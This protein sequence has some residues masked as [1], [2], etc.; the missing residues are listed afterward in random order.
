MEVG[1]V[2]LATVLM[3]VGIYWNWRKNKERVL[4]LIALSRSKGWRFDPHDT[5]GL[6][7][8]WTGAPFGKGHS[9]KASNVLTGNVDSRPFVAF[10]Y[11]Y[12]E[13]STDSRGN[14]SDT[15]YHVHVCVLRLPTFLPPLCLT[16][17]N[18]LS[19]IGNALGMDDIELESEDFNRRFKVT[20]GD[21]KFASDVLTP[22]TMQ[23]L[24]RGDAWTWR[25]EG[26]DLLCYDSGR[27]SPAE[28]LVRTAQMST[29]IA[30]IP[31][32]VW[33]DRGYDPHQPL[34]GGM[35]A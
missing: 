3:V 6:A 7:E 17:E 8:R 30:G 29:F 16:P 31:A 11:Q 13:S 15:T 1:L 28:I 10:D 24:L 20:C 19:R 35:P 18:V 26:T 2:L 9:R 5:F 23:S 33:K 12:T 32:F 14:R 25:I 27:A 4:A 22:R 34:Q 21:R